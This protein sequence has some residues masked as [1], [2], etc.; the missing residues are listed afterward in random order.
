MHE[1]T[2]LEDNPSKLYFIENNKKKYVKLGK[3]ESRKNKNY[4]CLTSN[5]KEIYNFYNKDT[6]NFNKSKNKK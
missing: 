2:I 6:F 1:K 4:K 3:Q 5:F